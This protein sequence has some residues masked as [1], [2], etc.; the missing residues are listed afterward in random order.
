MDLQALE[1]FIVAAKCATYV[2]NGERA[3]PSRMGSHDLTF[4]DGSWLYRDSY[5]GGTDFLGQEVVWQAGT[6]VWAMSYY[7]YV[8]RPDL[9][10]AQRAG[11]T[12]KAAL[13]A[14]YRE[15]RFL[16]GF[17]WAGPDGVYRDS[18]TGSVEHFKGREVIEVT[19][20][21]AYALDYLG[22]LIKP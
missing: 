21:E 8:T 19:G 15:G 10:D 14:L 13:S 11:A 22:G 12:I 18:S 2:G 7:G 20:V 5:F 1:A 16:G 3:Q 9:I 4:A 17:E 6:P